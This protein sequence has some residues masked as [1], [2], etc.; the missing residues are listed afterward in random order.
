[1]DTSSTN[2]TQVSDEALQVA[3]DRATDGYRHSENVV[4]AR[5]SNYLVAASVLLGS[6]MA[7]SSHDNWSMS[8][9]AIVAL[10]GFL[11]S[12]LWAF[13]GTRQRKF[14]FLQMDVIVHLENQLSDQLKR[15]GAR[16]NTPTACLQNGLAVK[17]SSQDQV[18]KLNWVEREMKSRN[19]LVWAPALFGAAFVALFI[20][21]IFSFIT[22]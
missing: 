14:L 10:L 3:I 22:L 21:T 18:I 15:V 1:M 11:L 16:T 17:L 8:L 2:K 7:F 9:S 5:L 6:G 19:L 4:Q 12:T 13:L 20:R